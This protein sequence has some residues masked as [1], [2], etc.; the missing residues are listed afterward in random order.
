M[1]I[2]KGN[3]LNYDSYKTILAERK[4]RILTLTLNRSEQM[5]AIDEELHE[6]LSRIFYDVSSD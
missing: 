6:E 2:R 3:L 5:N 1:V 4:N